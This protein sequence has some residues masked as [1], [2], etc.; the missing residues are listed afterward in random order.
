M[1]VLKGGTA[2]HLGFGQPRRL[3]VDLDFNHIGAL[4]RQAMEQDR[5][6]V[7]TALERI[8]RAQGYQVQWP[9]QAHAGR[10]CFLNYRN[11]P[12]S[13]DRIEVDLNFLHRQLLLPATVQTM[14]S[15]EP[16]AEVSALILSL[17]ELCAGKLCALLD[18]LAPRDVFDV[19]CLPRIAPGLLTSSTFRPLFIAL[20]GALL[21]PLHSYL[22]HRTPRLTPQQ[23][24]D[25]L[26]PMLLQ[27]H[28]P[29]AEELTQTAWPLVEPLLQLTPAEQEY[30]DRLQRGELLP[31]L[32]F[33]EDPEMAE[34]LRR[35]PVLQWKA[36]NAATRW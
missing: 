25:Q 32:L 14:W 34:R 5:P 8:A 26:H 19:A 1:L 18:R 12:G 29:G 13:P 21:H 24:R 3:S 6:G 22:G 20:S 10:K 35:H 16:A 28:E 36:Q 30:V 7:E 23:V 2:L 27:D 4:E 11:Q 33:P 15:P 9:P 31:E 17:P